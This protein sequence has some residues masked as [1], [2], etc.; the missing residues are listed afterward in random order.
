MTPENDGFQS[1]SVLSF[2]LTLTLALKDGLRHFSLDLE[3][4]LNKFSHVSPDFGIGDV[5]LSG[6]DIYLR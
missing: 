5:I 2:T 1:D 3:N 4:Y 6:W